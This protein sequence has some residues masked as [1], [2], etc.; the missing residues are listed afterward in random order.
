VAPQPKSHTTVLP[1]AGHG[2][3][4]FF[5]DRDAHR[6][7]FASP[8]SRARDGLRN[9]G[10]TW[11]NTLSDLGGGGPLHRSIVPKCSVSLSRNIHGCH[12]SRREGKT[13][14][15]VRMHCDL[16]QRLCVYWLRNAGTRSCPTMCTSHK[17]TTAQAL[18]CSHDQVAE[19]YP[20]IPLS[21]RRDATTTHA[22]RPPVEGAEHPRPSGRT[23][24]LGR[25]HI[26]V[27]AEAASKILWRY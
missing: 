5:E 21:T 13:P 19:D 1:P 4:A 23:F 10:Q 9:G 7:H 24:R 17:I 16:C 3:D 15:S 11:H 26:H 27:V 25:A 14:R 8:R 12:G 22:W 18:V 6:S 2:S 20:S